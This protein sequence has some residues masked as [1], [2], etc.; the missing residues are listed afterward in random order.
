MVERIDRYLRATRT[1]LSIVGRSNP[2]LALFAKRA[3][4]L[5]TPPALL[6]IRSAQHRW[7]YL[8]RGDGEADLL[9][10]DEGLTM[11]LVDLQTL[12][13]T[14]ENHRGGPVLAWLYAADTFRREAAYAHFRLMASAA[15]SAKD[16][17]DDLVAMRSASA[18]RF[19]ERYLVAHELGHVSLQGSEPWAEDIVELVSEFR[20]KLVD[21]IKLRR[22]DP[23]QRPKD[24][25]QGVGTP[26]EELPRE[27]VVANF[28]RMLEVVEG[29]A[30]LVEE[31]A[32]D[33]IASMAVLG[34]ACERNFLS[35]VFPTSAKGTYRLALDNLFLSV[36]CTKLLNFRAAF[37]QAAENIVRPD[38]EYRSTRRQIEANARHNI[39]MNLASW[40]QEG[41]LSHI[42]YEGGAGARKGV[43]IEAL[44]R[45]F[46]P[47]LL[48]DTERFHH[49]VFQLTELL[50][51]MRDPA[52]FESDYTETFGYPSSSDLEDLRDGDR[53][54][55]Q[56]RSIVP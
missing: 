53:L 31:A 55:D 34:H 44:N 25:K 18:E 8:P 13:Q 20:D 36:R 54:R 51:P 39:A 5:Q 2:D 1:A 40:F 10:M 7:E 14:R 12:M 29:N 42:I 52:L 22:A 21:H 35:D 17:L 45:S 30:E 19:V 48:K 41:V 11:S 4:P 6:T 49:R 9:I 43:G 38:V 28:D 24:L 23:A 26:L 16:S 27:M 3:L 50:D 37:R 33:W 56:L 32:C 47:S 15:T 46:N